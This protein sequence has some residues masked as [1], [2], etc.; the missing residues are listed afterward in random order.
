MQDISHNSKRL[1]VCKKKIEASCIGKAYGR[2][3]TSV[4]DV[5]L[6]IPQLCGHLGKSYATS[7]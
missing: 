7:R 4:N 1:V 3:S 5:P 6:N 2:F